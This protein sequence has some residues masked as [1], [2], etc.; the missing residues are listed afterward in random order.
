MKYFILFICLF[1][2]VDCFEIDDKSICW[3][4]NVT[5]EPV[6][7]FCYQVGGDLLYR[8][9]R[10]D[11][12][13]TF[14]AIDLMEANLTTV[15]D[16]A[17]LENLQLS[18]IDLRENPELKISSSGD[19][20]LALKY[21]IEL[22]VPKEVQCPGGSKVWANITETTAPEGYDCMNQ[23]DICINSTDLCVADESV[24]SSNGPR[25][26]ECLCKSGYHGYKC[27]RYGAFPSAIFFGS[28]GGATIALSIF[29][30]WTQR[31]HVKK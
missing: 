20:L 31:R 21:L 18:V 15:P 2:L 26:Y 12:N 6:I 9:C 16:F 13:A 19:E 27:L 1:L 7:K 23:I 8:C 22:L 29:L 4:K 28:T 5:S 24:C 17:N 30:F 25:H 11:D 14:L 3:G 10:A